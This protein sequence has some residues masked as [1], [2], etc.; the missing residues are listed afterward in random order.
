M[1]EDSVYFENHLNSD[2]YSGY[3]LTGELVIFKE[4]MRGYILQMQIDGKQSY[5]YVVTKVSDEFEHNVKSYEKLKILLKQKEK[6]IRIL[7]KLSDKERKRY[8]DNLAEKTKSGEE[9]TDEEL[10]VGVYYNQLNLSKQYAQLVIQREMS[11]EI[12]PNHE[13]TA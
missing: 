10:S 9:L 11:D 4:N 12:N 3:A 5:V 1:V 13:I 6:G 2:L 7:R 8:I